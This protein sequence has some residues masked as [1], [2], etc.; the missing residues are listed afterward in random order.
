MGRSVSCYTPRVLH[1]LALV[2]SLS[3]A[4]GCA[5]A[6]RTSARDSALRGRELSLHLQEAPGG[7]RVVGRFFAALP[8]EALLALTYRPAL[9]VSLFPDHIAGIGRWPMAGEERFFVAAKLFG[10]LFKAWGHVRRQE[11][12]DGARVFWRT[13]R[14]AHGS[15]TATRRGRGCQLELEGY[16][17]KMLDLAKAMNRLGAELLLRVV[18]FAGRARLEQLWRERRIPDTLPDNPRLASQAGLAPPIPWLQ[19]SSRDPIPP[20][21]QRF[22]SPR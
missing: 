17:P 19:G 22:V 4:A 12:P 6:L 10:K 21:L 13:D 2:L 18:A 16:F 14:G 8:P 15:A 7:V 3:L 11:L 5:G 20:A 1:A 9:L